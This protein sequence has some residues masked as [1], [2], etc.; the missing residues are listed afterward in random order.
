M[1][2]IGKA[3][4][5]DY[6]VRLKDFFFDRN[7]VINAVDDMTHKVLRWFGGRVREKT[8]SYLGKPKPSKFG[9]KRMG[10]Y[11]LNNPPRPAPKPPIPRVQDSATVTLRNVQ[12]NYVK[13]ADGGKARAFVPKYR[14]TQRFGGKTAPELQEFGGTV[15][16]RAKVLHQ[17]P[18][19]KKRKR[20]GNNK[21]EVKGLI[22]N[23]RFP[24]R[25]FRL[26][27][28]PYLGANMSLANGKTGFEK[29]I[30]DAKKRIEKGQSP[31]NIGRLGRGRTI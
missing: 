2:I 21:R 15:R 8:R 16:A 11:R 12:Y 1:G 28:R 22:F 14:G 19:N 10:H 7:R 9:A 20:Q 4:F 3:G 27:A 30:I 23:D 31:F 25:S 6:D 18:E 29:A 13:T 24:M 17:L 5:I 26:P